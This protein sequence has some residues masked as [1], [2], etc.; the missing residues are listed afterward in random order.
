MVL[1]PH[2]SRLIQSLDIR[3]FGSLKILMTLVMEL[4]RRMEL[5]RNLKGEW[6]IE[7]YDKVF[8]TRNI[9]P[10][11]RIMGILSLNSS[12]FID[13]VKANVEEIIQLHLQNLSHLS[14]HK[15]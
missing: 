14:K 5:R 2:S 12:N 3:V 4:F 11:F 13:R 10:R 6:N 15:F 9:R 1:P 8:S 7:T